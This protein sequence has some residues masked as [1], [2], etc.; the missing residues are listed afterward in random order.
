MEHIVEIEKLVFGG[1]GLAR[2]KN[3]KV[4]FVPF[5]LPGEK[6]KIK[7][8]QESK[9]FA[10]A[11]LLEVLETSPHRK[12]PECEYYQVCGG[13]QFQH[14]DY[15]KQVELKADILKDTFF[16]LGWKEEIPLEAY[17]PSPKPLYYRNRLRLHVESPPLNMGFV[18]RK[19]FEVLGIKR[20]FL[21]EKSINKALEGLWKSKAWERL[22]PYSKRIKIES[23]PAEEKACVVFWSSLPP[24]KEDL[25]RLVEEIPGVFC[26]FY[27]LRGKR[28]KG[29]FPEDAPYSGRRIFKV[30]PGLDYYIQPG[31]FVQTNWEINRLIIESLLSLGLEAESIL[32]L[33]CGMGNFLLPFAF[34]GMGKKFLGVDTDIRAIEDAIF[35]AERCGLSSVVDFQ[36]K[37]A[38]EAL[39]E[40]V[41]LGETYDLVLLDPPRGGCKELMRLLPEVAKKYIIYLSCDAPT[42]VRDLKLLVEKGYE[43][44]KLFLF[45]MFPQ[46]Y[47]FETL[48]I[49]ELRD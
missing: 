7:V 40:Q 43:L 26:V 36:R 44:K 13:C 14:I 25:L 2:L 46:T 24:L 8:V 10:E 34:K 27:W 31:V 5:V 39:Y 29:P 28:P 11:E 45:D 20:C 22:S 16:R 23:S 4:L 18:K 3:G 21:A 35:T 6:V 9:D 37:S 33:H 15:S 41:K 38:L 49:L 1:E 42:L 12:K 32:D 19:S 48:A 47:H 30:L 17:I